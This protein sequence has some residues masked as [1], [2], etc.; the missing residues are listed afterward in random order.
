ML[1]TP[2][3]LVSI[4]T[5]NWNNTDLT[6]KFLESTKGLRY[7][8]YEIL[9]CDM[10]S[11]IDPSDVITAG[12]YQN[13]RIL[14]SD[15]NLGWGPGNNW[16]IKQAKGDFYFIVNNDTEV[17]S[18]LLDLLLEPFFEKEYSGRNQI[19]VT[20]PK[21]K[22]FFDPNVIQYAG[23]NPVNPITGRNSAV[24]NRAIDNGQ[25]DRN[26][27]TWSAHG[28]A[29]MVRRDVL[30]KVGMFPEK[31]FIYYDE[32]DLSTRIIKG[33]Y[34]ILFTGKAEIY[35]KESMAMGKKSSLKT[36]FLTRNRILYMRRNSNKL[37]Y[38]GFMAFFLLLS[39]PKAVINFLSERKF[40]HIKSYFKAIRWN[41]K[42][43]KYSIQ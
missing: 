30:E 7:K 22:Y 10:N 20:C 29:M 34:K 8:N 5:L 31:F 33:G 9:V 36:Y 19:G 11:D 12:N 6:L 39:T 23:F 13:T 17:T 38:A 37:Q 4:I 16:G 25:Y 26:Y 35:H 43:S 18:D 42:E 1:P 3:P 14:K 21:I 2:N 27:F 32:L 24:G 40:E 15:K 41:F 28:C